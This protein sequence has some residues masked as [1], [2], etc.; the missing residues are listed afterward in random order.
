MEWTT[1]NV[2]IIRNGFD[3]ELSYF[4]VY[5]NK[6]NPK[7]LGDIV[8][9]DI[10]NMSAIISGLNMGACPISERWEDGNGNTCN[11]EGF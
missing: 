9:S 6:P 3:H 11:M 4:E 7:Y 2:T 1:K 10:E 8:P 5:D